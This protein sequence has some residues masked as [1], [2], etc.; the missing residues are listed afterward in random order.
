MSASTT[1]ARKPNVLLFGTGEY[2]TGFVDGKAA[3]TDKGAGI[4]AL[5][6][7]DLRAA[8]KVGERIALCTYNGTKY[9]GLRK[10]MYDQIE[11]KYGLD[12][13]VDTFPADDKKDA[14]AYIEALS[15]FQRGT[16]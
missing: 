13:K 7:F 8:G 5:A 14:K 1:P 3:T 15:T 16:R 2:T 4:V 6:F 12:T 10:H 11:A 9:P